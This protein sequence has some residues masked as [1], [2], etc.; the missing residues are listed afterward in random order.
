MSKDDP[1]AI[2]HA[3]VAKLL[4]YE[5]TFLL[6]SHFFFGDYD[7]TPVAIMLMGTRKFQFFDNEDGRRACAKR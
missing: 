5:G 3:D 1:G 2:Q 6:T 7:E 4:P